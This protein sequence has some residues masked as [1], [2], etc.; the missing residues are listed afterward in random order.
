M[1]GGKSIVQ[2]AEEQ[3]LSRDYTTE[4][5]ILI[6]LPDLHS[7]FSSQLFQFAFSIV[8][9]PL[10]RNRAAFQRTSRKSF[11]ELL[12]VQPS[13]LKVF[14]GNFSTTQ[15]QS[16]HHMHSLIDNFYP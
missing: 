7:T 16:P 11:P 5:S 15:L 9:S 3:A 6:L 1:N 4:M 8:V 14:L 13:L 10:T 2:A 12:P